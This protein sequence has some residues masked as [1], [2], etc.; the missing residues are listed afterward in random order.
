MRESF[1]PGG[2][3]LVMALFFTLAHGQYRHVNALDLA[4]EATLL[5]WA[6]VIGYAVFRTGSLVPA[7]IAHAIIN[8][9][10]EVGARWVELVATVLAILFWRQ[11]VSSWGGRY[12]ARSAKRERLACNITCAYRSGAYAGDYHHGASDAVP[13][14]NRMRSRCSSRPAATLP[15]GSDS[16][17]GSRYPRQ[18]RRYLI[19]SRW[20]LPERWSALRGR[21]SARTCRSPS[22]LAFPDSDH[23]PRALPA[24]GGGWH[25]PL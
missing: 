6:F 13:M 19:V 8:V 16:F 4:G 24:V 9:P 21:R 10:M 7:I 15:V 22:A 2:S 20:H 11:A 17:G 14:A 1:S 3:L 25:H 18:A 5:V 12:H 23:S